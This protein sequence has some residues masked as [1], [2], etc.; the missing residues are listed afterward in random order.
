MDIAILLSGIAAGAIL[1]QTS[2]IAPTVFK[3]LNPPQAKV[4]LRTVFP[5][6]FNMLAALGLIML[7]LFFLGMGN[8]YVALITITLSLICGMLVPATNKAR[9]EGNVKMFRNL[10]TVS[11]VLTMIVLL[12]NLSWIVH[13]II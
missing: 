9:D 3:A 12:S 1:F 8:V 4:F 6:L 11:V 2:I 5:K 7:I 10:H 13:Q